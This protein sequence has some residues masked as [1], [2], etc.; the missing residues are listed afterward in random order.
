MDEK[1]NRKNNKKRVREW[2]Q[3]SIV[4]IDLALGCPRLGSNTCTLFLSS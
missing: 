3:D 2:R 4:V 1:G